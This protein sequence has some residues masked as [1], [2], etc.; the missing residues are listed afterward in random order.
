MKQLA[1]LVAITALGMV[2]PRAQAVECNV[3][4]QI[5]KAQQ[6]LESVQVT[7]GTKLYRYSE[8]R[9]GSI[10]KFNEPETQI[11]LELLEPIS[12]TMREIIITKRGNALIAPSGYDIGVVRRANGIQWNYW[13]TEYV[14]RAPEGWMVVA[15]KYPVD[16]ATIIYTP[17]SSAL[18][19]PTL[20]QNGREY[21]D[22]LAS[23]A[24]NELSA[25]G[26]KLSSVIHADFIAR[27]APIEH[28]D[29]GEFLLDP[30]WTIERIYALIG[31]NREHTAAYTCNKASACGLMQFT[32][33]TYKLMVKQYPKAAL[34]KTFADGAR[35]PLNAMK[36]A[37]LLHE[38][39]LATFK[40]NLTAK[41]FASLMAD[42]ELLEESLSSAYNTGATRTILVL[43]AYF[44]YPK[45]FTDW[46]QAKGVGSK[47]KL[48]AETKGYITKLRYLRDEWL[49]LS[50]AFSLE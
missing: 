25:A 17:Y 11:A 6:A 37:F 49:P 42:P 7:L 18:G 43:R 19:T 31:A 48:V 4:E 47:A 5:V 26:V 20:V 27:L 32:P 1:F 8:Q 41:Q 36:A 44:T 13:A 3:S 46:A 12:C 10:V 50:L 15:N 21:L 16:D 35:D 28:M 30:T 23:R 45:K 40:R 29:L 34:I 22:G 38:Y 2:A 24:Y 39:N 9:L 14:V 33:G